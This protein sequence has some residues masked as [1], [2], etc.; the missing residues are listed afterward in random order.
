M[1]I[2]W[3][4]HRLLITDFTLFLP[5][6][7]TLVL[8]QINT[9]SIIQKIRD[10]AAV[11]LT[12]MI[13]ISLIGF[14]VQ[15]AFVGGNGNIFDGQPTSVGS[16]NGKEIDIIEFNKKVNQVEQNYRSQGMQ[17]NE[18]MTQN[19]LENIWNGYIQ[20]TMIREEAKK[21][22]I[23]VTP[24]E[25]G[26]TL[27]SEDAPQE[28]KQ[29]FVDRNTGVFDIN[30]AKNWFNN[31][32]KTTQGEDAANVAEQ[33]I[34]PIETSLIAQKYGS[35][36][37]QGTYI[38]NWVI[39]KTATDNT[40]FA[41]ISFV[42]VPYS[43]IPDSSVVVSSEEIASYIKKRADEFKQEHVKSIAYVSIAATPTQ[44]DSARVYNQLVVLKEELSKSTDPRAFVT[45]NNSSI[46]F[47]DG[48][49]LKSKL[50]VSV[51]DSIIG[52]PTGGV[53]GPYLDGNNFVVARKIETR[54]LPDSVKCRH[55]LVGTVDPQSGQMRRSDTAAR[56]TADSVFALI[57][58]GGDFG[59]LAAAVSEDQGSKMNGGEY[60]FSSL[61]MGN[62]AKEFGDF[63]F[64]KPTGSR[65]I[66]KTSFGYH[67]IEVLNQKNFEE[68]YKVAY[69][70]KA[71]MPSEE[72]DVAAAN[73]ATLFVSSSKDP[74]SFDETASKM[75]LSKLV[76]ENI[77]ALDFS[78]GALSSR[79]LVKW[80]FEN[81]VG[82]V[83]EPFDLK[84][85]Y[86]VA[87][88]T[89]EIKEGVQPP[90]VA[91]IFVEPA[92]R[93]TKKAALIAKKAGS[94]KNLEKLAQAMGGTYGK[95]DTVRFSDPFVPN[96]GNET[97][98]IGAAFYKKNQTAV[99][100][101]IEGQNGVYFIKTDNTG[102]LPN[103]FVDLQG[104]KKAMEAQMKQYAAYSTMESLRRAMKIVDKRREAGY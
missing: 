73:T 49:V 58:T 57:K 12:S 19:I 59:S 68:A 80:V 61:D 8:Q 25:L 91:R 17:S 31:L 41:S 44:D 6:L 66:V 1:R 34:K 84:D 18:M 82:A 22:G 52:M 38:P 7:Y 65:E 23:V 71:I 39:E 33:L 102:A 60:S 101:A 72:T 46:P 98:V 104:Q 53:M 3:V 81:K 70:S 92:I 27:F 32:K 20:E 99:S 14:L 29:L 95:T 103:P 11:F 75:K 78:A 62:L 55:I 16:I 36:I 37:S 83:S 64:Y 30:A 100:E 51:K 54:S 2:S 69:V 42:A 15:D 63:I 77:K 67:I 87:V 88:I 28:F 94:E 97:K 89:N 26:A 86:V 24:K 40:A 76:A 79:A 96:L 21:I 5:R 48:Y 35:L 90:N 93:N 85:Q 10:K 74:K 50:Q 56:K 4:F 47:F 43:S 45:R 13:A 9:M